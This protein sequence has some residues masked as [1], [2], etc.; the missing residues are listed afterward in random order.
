MKINGES[1]V[2]AR[3][4][5]GMLC[6][7]NI[8][9]G[10]VVVRSTYL[11][12]QENTIVYEQDN[13]YVVD[14]NGGAITRSP[15]SRILDYSTHVLYGVKNFKHDEYPNYE[16]HAFFVW[17]DYETFK[18]QPFARENNQSALLP[19]TAAKL[20][21]GGPFK[22]IAFGDSI[23]EGADISDKSQCYYNRYVQ[24]LRERF[25]KAQIILENGATGG[26]STVQGLERLEEK[27]LSRNPDLVLVAFG[28]N[29]H[30]ISDAADPVSDFKNNLT[31]IVN[32]IRERTGAEVMIISTFPPNPEWCYGSHRMDKYA[33][34]IEQT[35]S[36]FKCA[37]ADVYS[38][39]MKVLERKDFSSMLGNNINHPSYFGHWLYYKVL[40]AIEF[41][42]SHKR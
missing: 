31:S 2:L 14:Y 10:S 8:V 30:N 36:E 27:V 24:L 42:P 26:D 15:Q 13:D 6:F 1:L 35:A 23:T 22:I 34:A 38:T 16:N 5:P 21:A 39:W 11:P 20:R 3:Q 12:N 17:V 18:D 37:Y 7:D 33:K 25:P 32:T 19:N 41:N 29:D 9:P 40:E 28:M 4:A